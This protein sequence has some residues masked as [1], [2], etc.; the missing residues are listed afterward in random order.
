VPAI[1]IASPGLSLAIT[2]TFG[3]RGFD[4]ALIART[5]N[6]LESLVAQFEADGVTADEAAADRFG[7][8]SMLE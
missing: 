6:K 7:G 5:K 3:S 8:V 4:V 1:A 2:R